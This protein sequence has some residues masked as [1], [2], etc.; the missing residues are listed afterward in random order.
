MDWFVAALPPDVRRWLCPAVSKF[1]RLGAMPHLWGAAPT[2][3]AAGDGRAQPHIRRQSRGRKK[4]AQKT[5]SSRLVTQRNREISNQ[6]N[7]AA[8]V[9]LL[10][11]VSLWSNLRR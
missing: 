7:T 4:L 8:R 2:L 1:L 10:E 3:M 5:R 9:G 6:V 11:L